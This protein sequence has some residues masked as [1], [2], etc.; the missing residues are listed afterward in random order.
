[1]ACVAALLLACEGNTGPVPGSKPTP[2]GRGKIL[3]TLPDTPDPNRR[4]IIYLHNLWL[5]NQGPGV[6]HPEFGE[7]EFDEIL[8]ALAEHGPT[9]IGEVRSRGADPHASARRVADQ[10]ATLQNAG[11][12]AQRITVVGFSKGGAIA[13]FA[14]AL[15][16]DDEINFVFLAACGSW[17]ESTP[18]LVP[19]GR[20]LSIRETSDEIVGS[21]DGLFAR[22]PPSTERHE[23]VVSIGGGHGAFFRPDPSWIQPVVRWAAADDPS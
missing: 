20:L 10:V 6:P 11:V 3:S 19:H 14:A 15:I 22:S 18:N 17:L 4:Y 21:C 16:A 1:M 23:I 2:G 7:Y 8:H 13:I 12:P 5:E 9:V